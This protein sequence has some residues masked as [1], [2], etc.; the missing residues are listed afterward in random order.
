[1]NCSHC[2]KQILPEA[3]FCPCCGA[4]TEQQDLEPVKKGR[5][6][7]KKLIIGG[8]VLA[9][10][11]ASCS[12][13][14][15]VS[16]HNAK[17]K[18]Y[19]TGV[20]YLEEGKYNE[21]LTV[22]TGLE[23]FDDAETMAGLAQAELD[24]QEVGALSAA[25]NYERIAE[26]LQARSGFYENTETGR[27]DAALAKEYRTLDQA[28][29]SMKAGNYDAAAGKLE[30]ADMTLRECVELY[31]LCR[32]YQAEQEQDWMEILIN[33]YAIQKE[34]PAFVFLNEPKDRDDETVSEAKVRVPDD[35]AQLLGIIRADTT[36]ARQLKATAE[37]GLRYDQGRTALEEKRYTE[38]IRIFEE[39]D[40]FLDAEACCDEAKQ[41]YEQ[42]IS[43][44][45]SA[46]EYF[47]NGEFFKAKK[48]YL[49]ADPYEDAAEKADAC[50]QPMPENGAFKSGNGSAA[51]FTIKNSNGDESVF[52]K[53]YDTSDN[54]VGQTFI[55]AGKSVTLN[56]AAGTYTI[57]V[58]Y[59]T[60]WY[61]E[62]DLFGDKGSYQ[63]LLNGSDT[64]FK[65]QGGYTYT[66]S[67]GG[68][69]NGNVGSKGLGDA[70][71]M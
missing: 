47:A 5:S 26:I 31:C 24:Y 13:L 67:L 62:T 21:A 10:A 68:V 44:Y 18:E 41:K 52:V 58:G 38:A 71:G 28:Y 39:I 66:L 9:V 45:K 60:Q 12:I 59:G 15:P 23:D 4:K 46:E 16:I 49:A 61:G 22:F 2:G 36:E 14:I 19:N 29:Q 42:C 27:R 64:S 70:G 32:A 6:R 56:M 48:L 65:V 63:Q 33:L 37:N 55:S 25:R 3:K 8:I 57:K 11:A 54:A 1:M 53:L 17:Q 43:D 34:D 35:A 69:T 40:G 20:T 51:V 30:K 7:R 50:E